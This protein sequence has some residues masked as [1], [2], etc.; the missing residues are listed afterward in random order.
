MLTVF[1]YKISPRLTRGKLAAL[2]RPF[3]FLSGRDFLPHKMAPPDAA[4]LSLHQ[5]VFLW[6]AGIMLKSSLLPQVR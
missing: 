3:L 6:V 4:L 2:G 5:G 1:L